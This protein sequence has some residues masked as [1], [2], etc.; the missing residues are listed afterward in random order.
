MQG[1]RLPS[2]FERLPLDRQ[3]AENDYRLDS[4]FYTPHSGCSHKVGQLASG[5]MRQEALRNREDRVHSIFVFIPRAH[6]GS[7]KRDFFYS[8]H[9]PTSHLGVFTS[10]LHSGLSF[11]HIF[12][13][14]LTS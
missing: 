5:V 11:N 14:L 1:L 7:K 9:T 8:L 12:I 2:G 13:C 4:I 10:L 3:H 6:S